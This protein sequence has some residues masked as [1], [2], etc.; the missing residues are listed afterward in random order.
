MVAELWILGI[1]HKVA[2]PLARG[3]DHIVGAVAAAESLRL[4]RHQLRA[5]G[6]SCFVALQSPFQ[7]ALLYTGS[8]GSRAVP[9]SRFFSSSS[10]CDKGYMQACE[11][12]L[13][14]SRKQMLDVSRLPVCRGACRCLGRRQW[15]G[16]RPP[17]NPQ[18]QRMLGRVKE[19]SEG[20]TPCFSTLELMHHL[21]RIDEIPR[22]TLGVI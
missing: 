4:R 20:G 10:A 7:S 8:T 14:V 13:Q 17:S 18:H 11:E 5:G 19:A 2:R 15:V 1:S 12:A 9:P 16:L 3:I 6:V 22:G 21:S